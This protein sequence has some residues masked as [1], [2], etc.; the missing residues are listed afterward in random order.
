MKQYFTT[1]TR[2]QS[3]L[4]D[5]IT[6]VPW[7][8]NILTSMKNEDWTGNIPDISNNW[9]FFMQHIHDK[10]F[11]EDGHDRPVGQAKWMVIRCFSYGRVG[12]IQNDSS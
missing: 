9:K 8:Y 7:D 6:K 4:I 1:F 2:K 3:G 10:G 12:S 5:L 11:H